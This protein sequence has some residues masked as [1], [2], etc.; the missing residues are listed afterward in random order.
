VAGPLALS[1]VFRND[2]TDSMTAGTDEPALS[3]AR[4]WGCC[5]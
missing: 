3:T 2:S 1:P 4:R 5:R